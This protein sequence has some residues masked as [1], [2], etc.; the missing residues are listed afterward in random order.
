MQDTK[1][2]RV[3]VLPSTVKLKKYFMI[4]KKNPALFIYGVKP[5]S[6]LAAG[7]S[8]LSTIWRRLAT[9]LINIFFSMH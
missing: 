9:V 4:P 1:L 8:T 6:A 7:L 5:Y 2:E 3:L